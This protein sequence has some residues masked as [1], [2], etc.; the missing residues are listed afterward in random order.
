MSLM[1]IDI[2]TTGCKAAAFAEHGMCL[3]SAYREYPTL[4][5]QPGWAE[6]D[7][8]AVWAA[9]QEVIAEVATRTAGD[10]IAALAVSSMGEAMVPVSSS[11]EMLGN[12]ILMSDARGAE[13][14]DELLT[15]L[16]VQ[17]FFA[18][19]PNIPGRNY[20][21]PKLCWLRDHQPDL[22]HRTDTFL[23]WGDVVGFMLGC[24]PITSYSLANRTLLFD[25][26][27][28]EWS[29]QL[30]TMA[31]IDKAKLARPVPSGTLAGIADT[32][33]AAD[34]GLPPGVRIIVGGH[35]QCCNALGAGVIHPGKA[36]C[37]IGTVECITPVFG[38]MP[39]ASS[40]LAHGL[41]IEHHLLPGLY[42]AFLYNQ[43]GALLRWFRDTFATAETRHDGISV[44]DR[45][46]AEMPTEP[47]RLF[48]LPYF[49]MTGPPRYISDAT[50]AI[51][52][53]TT[54]TTRGEILKSIME[55]V[56]FYFLEGLHQL[57][58][59][60]IDTTEFI[61]TGGGATSDA[62][63]QIKAD[64]FGVPLRRPHVTEAGTL[65]AAMLAGLAT[66]IYV[67][68][69]DAV[70]QC[71]DYEKIFLPDPQH[72]AQYQERAAQFHQLFPALYPYLQQR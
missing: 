38:T 18:I 62:W 22:Y 45:L 16:D 59:L 72:H 32:R 27:H 42:V 10:P 28:E 65:G 48:T 52:G 68:P 67:S 57:A 51:L 33:R 29:D 69:D 34:L 49:E 31:N 12:S 4:H 23:L 64:I 19:N 5:P 37:G 56:T 54:S 40:M 11:R 9:I 36:V 71:V 6:L 35:D 63:L 58:D 44:Y 41:N 3:G 55:G 13:Y 14:T 70:A 46:G 25:L 60:G 2:G 66:G 8:H 1:G 43:G 30:L 20:S 47:T 17:Q 24:D 15:R 7:S 61:A 50:G 21:L 39:P 26:A 53:L